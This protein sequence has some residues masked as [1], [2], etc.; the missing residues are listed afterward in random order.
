MNTRL[1]E[2]LRCALW[3]SGLLAASGCADPTRA[4]DHLAPR[5]AE[6][7]AT[8]VQPYLEASCAT[9]DCHGAQGR[10]L[11]LYSELGLREQ[12]SLRVT[13]IAAKHEPMPITPTELAANRLAFAS[14]ALATDAPGNQLALR[15]PLAL[16][17]GGIHHQGRVHW[18]TKQDPGYLCLRG[19]LVGDIKQDLAAVCAQALDATQK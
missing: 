7:F 11:R 4:I 12:A 6:A 8:H 10:A 17:E 19:W 18:A 5:D 2:S 16:G 14:V 15:K 13:P 1:L 9:L 3:L